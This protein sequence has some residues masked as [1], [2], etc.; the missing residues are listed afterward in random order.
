M[1]HQETAK[2]MLD[3]KF[4]K[5]V[6]GAG[7]GLLGLIDPSYKRYIASSQHKVVPQKLLKY[8][9]P[10]SEGTSEGFGEYGVF[11][12]I[13]NEQGEQELE[14]IEA[15]LN[16]KGLLDDISN[17]RYESQSVSGCCLVD[18]FNSGEI[19]EGELLIR[20]HSTDNVYVYVLTNDKKGK[21]QSLNTAVSC[22]H[23]KY[24]RTVYSLNKV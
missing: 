8:Y 13:L 22:I 16:E 24:G 11:A 19:E 15:S 14:A 10:T 9:A 17:I 21:I 18:G 7:K 6:T 12:C 3:K 20:Q 1:I 5:Q 2:K 23:P 4:F